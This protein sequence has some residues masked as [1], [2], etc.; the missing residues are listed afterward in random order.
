MRLGPLEW[1]VA[2]P[3]NHRVHHSLQTEHFDRNF[4]GVLIIWDRLFGTYV[5]EGARP[6][7]HF[8]LAEIRPDAG[9]WEIVTH[10]WLRLL[11]LKSAG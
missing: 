7:Q 10:G 3:S 6:L 1:F 5:A 4:G 9:P 11:G 2:T 8:G